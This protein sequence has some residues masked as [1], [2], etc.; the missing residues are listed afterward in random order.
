MAK[1]KRIRK[2]TPRKTVHTKS[3]TY[4][5]EERPPDIRLRKNDSKPYK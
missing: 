3:M 5:I 2:P 4:K 1:I